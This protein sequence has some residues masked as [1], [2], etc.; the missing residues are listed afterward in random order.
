MEERV[1]ELQ[2]QCDYRGRRSSMRYPFE[3]V[4]KH[5]LLS[6][7]THAYPTSAPV[8]LEPW[9]RQAILDY[10][11]RVNANS[12]AQA[13]ARR[14]DEQYPRMREGAPAAGLLEEA[15]RLRWPRLRDVSSS[16]SRIRRNQDYRDWRFREQE[17]MFYHHQ[18]RRRPKF[19][20]HDHLRFP[21][22][23]APPPPS[24]P[25][26]PPPPPPPLPPSLALPPPF[27]L[28]IPPRDVYL[29]SPRAKWQHDLFEHAHNVTGKG[30]RDRDAVSFGPSIVVGRGFDG[31]IAVEDD[32][33]KGV[34]VDEEVDMEDSRRNLT[35]LLSD[36]K[37]KVLASTP[38]SRGPELSETRKGKLHI[39]GR[40]Q[41]V[42]VGNMHSKK[43]KNKIPSSTQSSQKKVKTKKNPA[44]SL[45]ASAFVQKGKMSHNGSFSHLLEP[46]PHGEQSSETKC[47]RSTADLSV[48]F[49]RSGMVAQE[50]VSSLDNN[51]R[52]YTGTKSFASKG[53]IPQEDLEEEEGEIKSAESYDALYEEKRLKDHQ[54]VDSQLKTKS[55][56]LPSETISSEKDLIIQG[57][58]TEPP[59]YLGGVDIGTTSA[60]QSQERFVPE[61]N[62]FSLDGRGSDSPA[63]LIANPSDCGQPTAESIS[64]CMTHLK[65]HNSLSIN[66]PSEPK[67]TSRVMQ[68]GSYQD[69]SLTSLACK[70]I[71]KLDDK[72][73]LQ[74]KLKFEQTE[75]PALNDNVRLEEPLLTSSVLQAHTDVMESQGPVTR[76]Q[77]LANITLRSNLSY[78]SSGVY[79]IQSSQ[80]EKKSSQSTISLPTLPQSRLSI[81]SPPTKAKVVASSVLAGRSRTWHRTDNV[82]SSSLLVRPHVIHNDTTSVVQDVA[83]MEKSQSAA[84][85][86]K[87]NSLVRAPCPPM[88]LSCTKSS[89]AGSLNTGKRSTLKSSPLKGMSATGDISNV[90]PGLGSSIGSS[91]LPSTTAF[92]VSTPAFERPTT[93][94]VVPAAKSPVCISV[95]PES[96]VPAS[97]SG[98]PTEVHVVTTG[99]QGEDCKTNSK[100]D[101]SATNNLFESLMG[102]PSLFKRNQNE[103]HIENAL[104]AQMMPVNWKSNQLIA[105]STYKKQGSVASIG[106]GVHLPPNCLVQDRYYKRKKNQLVR[107]NLPMDRKIIKSLEAPNVSSL[108]TEL[109]VPTLK[110]QRRMTFIQTKLGRVLKQKKHWTSQSSWV[111]TLDEAETSNTPLLQS[112]RVA[113]LLC[114]WKRPTYGKSGLVGKLK[115]VPSISKGSSLS[116]IRKKLKRLQKRD[117]VYTKSL[118]GFSLHRSGVLSLG[119]SNLKWTK[120]IEK[121]SK[122][123]SEEITMAV[124]AT[125][126]KKREAKAVG[127][128]ITSASQ[129]NAVRRSFKPSQ[130]IKLRARKSKQATERIL[131]VGLFGYKMDPSK[132]T[133]QMIPAEKSSSSFNTSMARQTMDTSKL[134]ALKGVTIGDDEYLRVGNGN[135]LV[136]DPKKVCR[137]LAS[138]KVRWS[139]HTARRRLAKK[140]QYCQ[141]FTRFGKCNKDDGK[142]PY[143][144]D[145]EKIAVCTKFLK[146]NC[147]NG[148]CDLTHKIIP[149]RMEDCSFF[150]QGFCTNENCPY[151]HVNVNPKAPVC[152]GFLKGYCAEGDK[153]NKKHTHVCPQYAATGE[154]PERLSCKLHHPKKKD[155]PKG[156]SKRK[157]GNI[158]K[159]RYFVADDMGISE[160]A[161][162]LFR[163]LSEEQI[164]LDT[165]PRTPECVEFI[166]LDAS[167][168]G[169]D[170]INLANGAMS[171]MT[172][173]ETDL[174]SNGGLPVD[175]IDMMIK[176]VRLLRKEQAVNISMGQGS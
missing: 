81:S 51:W 127:D 122:Q 87:G 17:P 84:Y 143:I 2:S 34:E 150:L 6:K 89:F 162:K 161:S 132:R 149:E 53:L 21:P 72:E 159:R 118:N 160:L 130:G 98:T 123:A 131:Q 5:E 33:S 93:P 9:D 107:S 25:P 101:L 168:E 61:C 103:D 47:E 117:T 166:S 19:L 135:K 109:E 65:Q 145:R 4:E 104:A 85:V 106:G 129:E 115:A 8:P 113:P 124:A 152:D 140:Q 28:S 102:D 69:I 16:P 3:A 91:G 73:R 10:R 49:R 142:C 76:D 7:H 80:L 148:S 155:K 44:Q 58:S 79:Q 90:V 15:D 114:P 138:E 13:H 153:C 37:D 78:Q 12:N 32:L 92:R 163:L 83:K 147:S 11:N 82:P 99:A 174:F 46:A 120:S 43:L 56:N 62:Y 29:P 128:V 139:L 175:D 18:M 165:P 88:G 146:G 70:A 23:T 126:K 57:D 50:V 164:A 38:G 96:L 176:P 100:S 144:H 45:S 1:R 110:D 141:F 157:S 71:D 137:V 31:Y 94:P 170:D 95:S 59:C 41:N 158:A 30:K 125:E 60:V 40:D 77:V 24:P 64:T 55:M 134:F 74:K 151:R 133:L 66:A 20:Q 14:C 108:D 97:I 121:R 26:P 75:K 68:E 54:N 86:R 36:L 156:S 22:T 27:P 48:V 167:E 169:V 172:R 154:C 67:L 173:S 111:W 171:S 63:T 105:D 112:R 136:R 39:R 116:L 35:S 52:D 42:N 119:G